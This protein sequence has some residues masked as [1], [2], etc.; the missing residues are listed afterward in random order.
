MVKVTSKRKS[1]FNTSM[2]TYLTNKLQK[3]NSVSKSKE[4]NKQDKQGGSSMD[5]F[6]EVIKK[7]RK[8][9]SIFE[10]G[11]GEKICINNSRL[12]SSGNTTNEKR[13]SFHGINAGILAKESANVD[14]K[15]SMITTTGKGA[16]AAF[17]YGEGSL[18][19]I[20]NVIIKTKG[21]FANGLS[22]GS[23]GTI[24]AHDISINT[25][26]E[27]SAAIAVYSENGI[28]DVSN[29]TGLC[30]GNNSPCIYSKGNI[31]ITDSNLKTEKSPG[32][33]V[34]GSSLV[35]N[36]T[37][38]KS[39]ESYGVMLYEKNEKNE[40]IGKCVFTSTLGS[41]SAGKGALF[42]VTNTEA[43]VTLFNTK[44]NPSITSNILVNACKDKW[45]IEGSNGGILN[46]IG[47]HQTLRG[48]IL[49][50][51]LSSVNMNLK[52]YTYFTGIINERNKGTVN[53][54]L[55][56]TSVW[57]LTGNSYIESLSD[58]NKELK[59]IV[60]N[61]YSI[62]YNAQNENNKWLD[63]KVHILSGGGKLI[64]A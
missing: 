54:S 49:C 6:N 27:N 1:L 58:E 44:L 13:S 37:A 21:N 48:D 53:I 22:A 38:I 17:S 19:D 5:R 23:R 26:G 50:D 39:K 2:L 61:G 24:Q 36:N 64:P 3:L 45:G 43:I 29:A 62:Y 33:I 28:I 40:E 14:I 7:I 20:D 63:S 31:V 41:I 11:N 18:I 34:E 32:A 9:E 12:S 59:N 25:E 56:S 35:M 52:E 60:D 16:N 46:L 51:E 15:N 57:T 30:E 4:Y 10:V 47:D 42:Y 8:N 55:D